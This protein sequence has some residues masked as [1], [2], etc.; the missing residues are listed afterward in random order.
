[1]A[2]FDPNRADRTR[3]LTRGQPAR[4]LALLLA[5]GAGLRASAAPAQETAADS[6][7]RLDSLHVTV[8]RTSVR[9]D[10]LPLALSVVDLGE[11]AV[12]DRR[13][14]LENALGGVPGVFVQNRRNFS[15][16]DRITMRGT[17]S[18]SQF[19][20]RGIQV[21]LDGIP[22]TLPDGQTA[23]GNLDLATAGRVE[24]IR[25]PASALYGNAS[26]GVIRVRTRPAGTAP[27]ALES[28]VAG[29]SHGFLDTRARASG[30]SGRLGWVAGLRRVEIDGFRDHAA[31]ERYTAN[32]VGRYGI[33]PETELSAVLNL[34]HLPFAENPSS[35]D[36]ETARDAPTTVRDFIVDQGAG[37]THTQVQAGIALRHARGTSELG[38]SL[39]GLHRSVRNPIPGTIIDLSRR[40]VGARIALT[41]RMN[42]EDGLRWTVGADAALQ[43]DDR[44]EFANEGVRDG[45]RAVAGDVQI[46]QRERVLGVGPFAQSI[47]R[48]G[49]A[50]TMTLA[51]RYDVYGFDVADRRLEDGNDSGS[52]TLT[53]LS[54]MAGL[55]YGP[56]PWLALYANFSSAFETPTT[57]ELSNDPSGDGGFNEELRPEVMRSVEAG[58]RGRIPGSSLTYAVSAY[59][60]IVDDAL[61][62]T[63]GAT[64]EVFFRNAGR[65]SRDGLEVELGGELDPRFRLSA[66]WTFQDFVLEEFVT[67]DGDFSGR[68]E[69]G[70]PRHRFV[71]TADG[72]LPRD[73]RTR[74]E[75]EWVD[76]FPVD[77]ANAFSN[78]SYR[79]VD[80][81]LGW[82]TAV[83]RA[84]VR[85]F[86]GV[87]NLLDERYNGSVVPNAFADRYYEPAPGREVYGGLEVPL[88][89]V[90]RD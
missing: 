39:W 87:E 72:R 57:S 4:A 6:A 13:V 35:L 42:G 68:A 10:E 75:F 71:A 82:E 58:V 84:R 80:L 25:G 28:T 21:I 54:P 31:A 51:A 29:A 1:M 23:L 88:P 32:L 60:G 2:R 3:E 38:A 59:R 15:L 74:V 12:P 5:L 90:R 19:G 7:P 62:P 33:A 44:V 78:P 61:I 9:P 76:A 40:A 66:A 85:P 56:A 27:L 64:E 11:T 36:R 55:T 43:H 41:G 24:L 47:L 50:W 86:L 30:R 63:Q 16:G 14:S 53:R 49:D 73:L 22:L 83:G 45:E 37:E 89:I 20:V 26:G 65:V 67:D 52:R 8:S 77:D 70:V 81:R 79:L 69:P 34:D 48:L 46:D 18:R 17:G